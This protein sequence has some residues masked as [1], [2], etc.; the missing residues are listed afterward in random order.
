M[1][2]SGLKI[3]KSFRQLAPLK[4]I[5]FFYRDVKNQIFFTINV[6]KNEPEII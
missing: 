5:I 2:P 1:M 6:R 3:A 4:I